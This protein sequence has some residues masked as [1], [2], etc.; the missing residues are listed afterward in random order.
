MPALPLV[1]PIIMTVAPAAGVNPVFGAILL[2]VFAPQFLFWIMPPTF[3]L[4]MKD[5]I[6]NLKEWVIFSTAFFLILLVVWSIW[7]LIQPLIGLAV[8]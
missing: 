4:A 3:A 5:S 1:I 8:V 6:G 7:V 2:P